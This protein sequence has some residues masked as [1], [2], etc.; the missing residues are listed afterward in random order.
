MYSKGKLRIQSDNVIYFCPDLIG[1]DGPDSGSGFT[2]TLMTMICSLRIVFRVKQGL[3]W[4]AV[5]EQQF[6]GPRWLGR[7]GDNSARQGW[8][9]EMSGR[10]PRCRLLKRSNEDGRTTHASQR[11]LSSAAAPETP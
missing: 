7:Q 1:D 3:W 6:R 2:A 4:R 8:S 10:R 11:Q 9:D 5:V